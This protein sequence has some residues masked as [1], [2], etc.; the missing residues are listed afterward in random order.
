MNDAENNVGVIST[1]CDADEKIAVLRIIRL[2][3]EFNDHM[4]KY[5]P[6]IVIFILLISFLMNKLDLYDLNYN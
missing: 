5:T 2:F 4:Y 3:L 1:E 6:E